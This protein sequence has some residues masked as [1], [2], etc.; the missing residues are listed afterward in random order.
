MFVKKDTIANKGLLLCSLVL[1]VTIAAEQVWVNLV[2][3]AL[4]DITVQKRQLRLCHWPIKMVVVF[5]QLD[6]IV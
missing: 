6:I 2:E 1:Q 4:Q 3:N 5:A